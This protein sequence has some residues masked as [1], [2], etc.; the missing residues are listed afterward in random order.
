MH[1]Q[2]SFEFHESGQQIYWGK[3]IIPASKLSLCCVNLFEGKSWILKPHCKCLN[4]ETVIWF[5]VDLFLCIH[6]PTF[7]LRTSSKNFEKK[8]HL[9]KIFIIMKQVVY[10]FL[11]ISNQ[12]STDVDQLYGCWCQ[13][14]SCAVACHLVVH[15]CSDSMLKSFCIMILID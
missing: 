9:K 8:N 11:W 14:R 6:D 12:T 13:P 15:S 5:S 4:P 2:P 10:V 7:T 3:I 1:P